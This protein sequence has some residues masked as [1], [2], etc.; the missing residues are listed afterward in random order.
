[1]EMPVV[2]IVVAHEFPTNQC[3]GT[4]AS[5]TS[6]E[7]A[8][9]IV[10]AFAFVALAYRRSIMYVIRDMSSASLYGP[11]C[12]VNLLQDWQLDMC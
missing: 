6:M 5:A 2:Y 7:Q 3:L 10:K 8:N 4:V 9:M 11:E 1:M 12:A